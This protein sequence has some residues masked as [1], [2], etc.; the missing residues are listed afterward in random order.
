MEYQCQIGAPPASK[1]SSDLFLRPKYYSNR[2]HPILEF[3]ICVDKIRLLGTTTYNHPLGTPCCVVLWVTGLY[4]RR[5]YPSVAF[6]CGAYDWSVGQNVRNVCDVSFES[7]STS[8]NKQPHI[9]THN[10][11][12]SV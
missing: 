10:T 4:I 8:N 7:I 9:Q 3:I 12:I 6:E 5:V 11:R 1:G 2:Y